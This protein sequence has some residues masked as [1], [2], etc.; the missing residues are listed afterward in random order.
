MTDD[1]QPQAFCAKLEAMARDLANGPG[2]LPVWSQW[3]RDHAWK[4]GLVEK[5]WLVQTI[6]EI[7]DR[8][9]CPC[10]SGLWSSWAHDA[11]GVEL[12]RVCPRCEEQV[13]ACYRPEVLYDGSYELDEDVEP[14]DGFDFG[15][16]DDGED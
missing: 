2:R 6:G 3:L 16:L 10:G 8:G 1:D 5:R 13:L 7:I 11:R 12:A 4:F 9:H 15:L 14:D